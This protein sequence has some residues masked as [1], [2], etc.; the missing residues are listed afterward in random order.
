MLLIDNRSQTDPAMNLAL[1]DYLVRRFRGGETVLCLYVNDAS[2]VI[3]RNQLPFAEARLQEVERRRIRIVRRL[4]GGGAV[5]HDPGNLNFSIIQTRGALPWPSPAE[6]LRPV[7][8]WLGAMGVPAHLNDRHDILVDGR[9]V[10][11][12]AQ[13]RT[14]DKCLT[15]GTLL[16]SADL[17]AL[18][19]VLGSDGEVAS[20]RGRRS[21]P[22]PVTNLTQYHPA[23]TIAEARTALMDVFAAALGKAT[24]LSLAPGD[25]EV[26]GEMAHSK[27]RSWEWTV[28]RSPEFQLRRRAAFPWGWCEALFKIQRGVIVSLDFRLSDAAPASLF[29]LAATL[30]GRRY[31]PADVASG[32]RAAAEERDLPALAGAVSNWLCAPFAWWR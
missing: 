27:Y 11:G 19:R 2:V 21:V 5:Y 16:V 18:Q 13:Y 32:V 25:W 15:H 3:G 10:T 29:S 7:R 4:S 31:H 20:Y 22:S 28:G 24:S 8:D 1:E 14:K 26:I 6:V 23:L 17:E 30:E 12:A 9:K